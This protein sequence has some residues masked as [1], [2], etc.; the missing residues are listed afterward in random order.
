MEPLFF[1]TDHCFVLPDSREW[2]VVRTY[3]AG[4]VARQSALLSYRAALGVA[5]SWCDGAIYAAWF[6]VSVPG[7]TGPRLAELRQG[8]RWVRIDRA[9][10]RAANAGAGRRDV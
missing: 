6:A 4:L 5:R 9:P 1:R 3:Q 7:V 8:S 10:G 2:L